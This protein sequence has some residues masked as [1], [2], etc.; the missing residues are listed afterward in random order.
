[1]GYRTNVRRTGLRG[2]TNRRAPKK[3]RS[4][5]SKV[6]RQRP[7]ARNQQRQIARV[8]KLAISNRKRFNSVY[9]D[10]Q[11][12]PTSTPDDL[13]Y[14]TAMATNTWQVIRITNFDQWI[15]VLRQD[16]N[17]NES[18]HTFVKRI[19]IN[20]RASLGTGY[21]N[22]NFFLVRARF[23]EANRD[24]LSSP[25]TIANGD[26]IELSQ[27]ASANVRLNPAKFKVLASNYCT[28]KT[29]TLI[30]PATTDF[31]PGDPTPAERKW[32]W[33][34]YPKIKVHQPST[35]STPGRW[36]AKAFE[37]LPYYDRLYVMCISNI[38]ANTMRGVW[39]CDPLATCVNQL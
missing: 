19:S 21:A 11:I 8:T 34:I 18:N 25:P 1:M 12:S 36:P 15:P 26:Y 27:A 38:D 5:I 22:C 3:R 7:T 6:Y 28:L 20:M 23:P 32:Q 14:V 13:G 16:T 30:P 37:T 39:Y 10:W 4:S 17:V 31:L 35:Q 29:T 9:T 2:S 33:N 24:L